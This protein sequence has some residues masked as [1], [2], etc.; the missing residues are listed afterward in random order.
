MNLLQEKGVNAFLSHCL[1]LSFP[2][3]NMASKADKVI[4]VDAEKVNVPEKLTRE[5][6]RV[7]HRLPSHRYTEK[8]KLETAASLLRLYRKQARLVITTRLHCALPCLAMGIPV[9]FFGNG[10]DSRVSVLKE[11]GLPIYGLSTRQGQID[12]EPKVHG[13]DP[14]RDWIIDTIDKRLRSVSGD[15]C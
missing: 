1:T 4:L 8:A 5:A 2:T 9:V 12:W 14:I 6:I 10:D 11:V 3:R 7:S 13:I 15:W